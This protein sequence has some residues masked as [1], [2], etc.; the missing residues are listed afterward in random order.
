M[1]GWG[2]GE[3]FDGVMGCVT[4][5]GYNAL[6]VQRGLSELGSLRDGVFMTPGEPWG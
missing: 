3:G 1:G 5:Q 6:R 2:G 4:R